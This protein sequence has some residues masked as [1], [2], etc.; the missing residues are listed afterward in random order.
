VIRAFLSPPLIASSIFGSA[1][2]SSTPSQI[3]NQQMI[4]PKMVKIKT[5]P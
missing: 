1:L 2:K 5:I 3:G 4:I